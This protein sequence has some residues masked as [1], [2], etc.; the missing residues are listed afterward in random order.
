MME[1]FN[2]LI[3]F[4]LRIY[5]NIIDVFMTSLNYRF[6]DSV[7]VKKSLVSAAKAEQEMRLSTIN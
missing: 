6:N 1:V 7:I 2:N 5:A 3:H 4:S